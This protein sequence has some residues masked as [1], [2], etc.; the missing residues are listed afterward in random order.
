[1]AAGFVNVVTPHGVG[2]TVGV[3]VGVGVGVSVGVTVGVGD[4]VIPGLRVGVGVGVNTTAALGSLSKNAFCC[5]ALLM[6]TRPSVHA[7]KCWIPT[8][9]P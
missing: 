1:M 7:R 4:G 2:V 9:L 3:G 6:A 8:V 5:E